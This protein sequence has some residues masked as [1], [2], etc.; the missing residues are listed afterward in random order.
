MR[1]R[2]SNTLN[3]LLLPNPRGEKRINLIKPINPIKVNL[4]KINLKTNGF[5]CD[6]DVMPIKLKIIRIKIKKD[7][8]NHVQSGCII[9]QNVHLVD[10]FWNKLVHPKRKQLIS[11]MIKLIKTLVKTSKKHLYRRKSLQK[12]FMN[13]QDI[14]LLT[15]RISLELKILQRKM[16]KNIFNLNMNKNLR[17][18]P[19]F[20]VIR[21]MLRIYFR[22][23]IVLTKKNSKCK[24][25]Y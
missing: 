8:I 9:Y 7:P 19:R 13:Y 2:Y 16:L 20:V 11:K 14:R 1:N 6:F 10:Q 5:L 3:L 21:E 24:R 15:K 22:S 12:S 18:T 4:K 23:L 17:L 25:K